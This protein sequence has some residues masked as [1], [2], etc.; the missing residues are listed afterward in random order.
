MHIGDTNTGKTY[1]A[2]EELK[3]AKSGAYLAPLRL[4]ALEVQERLNNDGV[5]CSMTTGEEEDII[6]GATHMSS[7]A[8]K[9][10]ILRN[11]TGTPNSGD[12]VPIRPGVINSIFF[13]LF[14]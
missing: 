6:E 10:E 8:E 3:K 1:Q 12:E 11:V 7:T 4:L 9:L 5:L 13:P 2:L 14:R